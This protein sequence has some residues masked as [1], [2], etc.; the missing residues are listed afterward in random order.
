MK[1]H[2]DA[3]GRFLPRIPHDPLH[4]YVIPQEDGLAAYRTHSLHDGRE[5]A[6]AA[7]ADLYLTFPTGRPLRIL[8]HVKPSKVVL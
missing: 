2:R 1:P 3:L 8:R 4:P 7:G 5:T 6:L